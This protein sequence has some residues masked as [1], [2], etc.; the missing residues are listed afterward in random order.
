MLL[1]AVDGGLLGVLF[2][3]PLF[4]GGRHDL[5]LFVF[6]TLT[7]VA[8]G[9]WFVRQALLAPAPWT[10]NAAY[11]VLMLAVVMVGLQIVPLPSGVL[12]RLS[13]RTAELLPLWTSDDDSP[14]TLG[15]WRTLSLTPGE[16]RISLA[17]LIAYALLFITAVQRLKEVEDVE[18][19]LRRIGLAAIIMA[20][21]GILQYFTSNGYFFWFYDYPNRDTFRT[22]NG[23]FTNRNHFAHFIVLGV[24]PLVTGII[25][26]DRL[27]SGVRKNN[28]P[29]R[30]QFLIPGLIAGLVIVVMA[31]CLSFSRGGMIAL[32]V[33]LTVLFSLC[34]LRG[35]LNGRYLWGGFAALTV[36]VGLLSVYGY[37]RLVQR[38]DSLTAGS[39]EAVDQSGSR[40]HIWKAN[41]SAIRDGWL[42]GAGAGSHRDLNPAYLQRSEPKDFSHAE[43]G[44]LQIISENGLPGAVL[45]VA[46]MGLCGAWSFQSLGHRGSPRITLAAIAAVAGLTAS[47]VH[48]VVDFVWFI[49]AC[50]S[51]NILLAAALSRLAQLARHDATGVA[52]FQAPYVSLT[53]QRWI[54]LT[55]AVGVLGGWA[56]WTLAGPGA[57]AVHWDNYRRAAAAQTES[58]LAQLQG[59]P[60]NG[61]VSPHESNQLL[62]AVMID[63]LRNVV[64]WNPDS[65][66]AHAR[67]AARYLQK[68]ELD[69][70]V[71]E[72][73]MT[74]TSVRDAAIAS[75]FDSPEALRAW[76]QRAFPES[77]QYLYLAHQH[78][79]QA[80][81]LG[82][83]Q[84]EV[85][86][87]LADLCFLE[88]GNDRHVQQ[89]IAQGLRV[90]PADGDVLFEVGKQCWREGRVDD[91]LGYW[92]NSYRDP[93][94]HQLQIIELL[95]GRIPANQFVSLFQPD[96]T[97]LPNLWRRYREH[98][99]PEDYDPLL[100]RGRLLN[101]QLT[102]TT[103]RR[104]AIR[105]WLWLSEM[106]TQVARPQDALDALREAYAWDPSNYPVREGLGWSLLACG[107]FAEAES[108]FAWC[109][110]RR[111]NSRSVQQALMRAS[112]GK[113][114]LA[115]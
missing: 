105:Q 76:L 17:V 103:E 86:L 98:G 34:R 19:L 110:N 18:R 5:G 40:R 54:E 85:Y 36:V 91:A 9:G 23:S 102:S 69:Q 59:N 58:A 104:T 32:G 22:A 107:Q 55:A 74:V 51:V 78:A 115:R 96:W 27:S 10:R 31:V 112:R 75:Q 68:F 82:P 88:G 81:R 57:G 100:A 93:G 64:L 49:P 48:S 44:Y 7:V 56:V 52:Q 33:S 61:G 79:R 70:L 25:A 101:D 35:L 28:P 21:L 92:S 113:E 73:A 30:S 43:N 80:I 65:A 14:V 4:F 45:M 11:A 89:Y 53:R 15:V 109:Q 84:G 94:T 108:H 111:P 62:T 66:R 114:G 95:A 83:L 38:M 39:L 71:S 63:H 2:I 42:S 50:M 106:Y 60:S 6:V 3:A 20:A 1:A 87:L 13:P 29:S 26:L 16:T 77:H 46:S 99:Q 37:D 41:L 97:T 8:A 67:L 90:R 72:N 12:Q 47:L 24:G